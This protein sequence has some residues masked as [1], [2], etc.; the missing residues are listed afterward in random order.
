[1][2]FV[3]S[4]RGAGRA[5][6]RV[7]IVVTLVLTLGAGLAS[8]QNPHDAKLDQAVDTLALAESLLLH[9]EFAGDAQGQ[10]KFDRH[11]DRALK[12]IQQAVEQ[13]MAAADVPL[14]R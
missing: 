5:V 14:A 8:A 2:D 4:I 9:A 1:M 11:L 12:L 7:A 6:C 10:R 13:I 3:P